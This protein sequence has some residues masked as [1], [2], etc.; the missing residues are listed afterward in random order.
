MVELKNDLGEVFKAELISYF[1]VANI[2]KRYVFYSLNET[3]ENGL[4]KMYV[5]EVNLD[6]II[7][8]SEMGNDEWANVKSIMKSML[9]EETNEN[10]KYLIWE[11]K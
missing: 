11:E 7:V 1:E 6:G 8:S 4:I 2:G 3:V 10:I 5:S 9:K